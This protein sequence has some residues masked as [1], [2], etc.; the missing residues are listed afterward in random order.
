MKEV[1]EYVIQECF[2]INLRWYRYQ[3]NY[4]QEKLAELSNLT[5]KYISDLERGKYC[6]SLAKIQD[7]AEAL[8]IEPY[9]LIKP[10]TFNDDTLNQ[11]KI[12]S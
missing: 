1:R 9:Q 4:T 5:A 10:N 8:E 3:K 7:L 2:S 12:K 11:N 6:P